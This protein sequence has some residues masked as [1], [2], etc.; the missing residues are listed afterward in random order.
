MDYYNKI[1][2]TEDGQTRYLEFDLEGPIQT[3]GNIGKQDIQVEEP[4]LGMVPLPSLMIDDTN[5]DF[6]MEVTEASPSMTEEKPEVSSN[7]ISK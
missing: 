4:F 3:Q 5:V 6:Q 7:S 1:A 2:F